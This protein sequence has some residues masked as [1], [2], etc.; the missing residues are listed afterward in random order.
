MK[1][2][3]AAS[4]SIGIV[5]APIDETSVIRVWHDD[6]GSPP[7]T[8]ARRL[9]DHPTSIADCV[10]SFTRDGCLPYNE[11]LVG[12]YR[13]VGLYVASGAQVQNSDSTYRDKTCGEVLNDL[14]YSR[15]FSCLGDQFVEL[16]ST[17]HWKPLDMA[18]VYP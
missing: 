16:E 2:P 3:V 9:L 5:I 15:I 12:P 8:V 14:G 4:G 13:V 11:W 18:T 6:V 10:R 7:S 1:N 17:G